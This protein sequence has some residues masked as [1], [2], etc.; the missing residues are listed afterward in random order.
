MLSAFAD[1]APSAIA[2]S[3]NAPMNPGS[4]PVNAPVGLSAEVPPAV[5]DAAPT[6]SSSTQD[7]NRPAAAQP[8][9]A[10]LDESDGR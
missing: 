5:T 9:T 4:W 7:R 1:T 10:R 2:S 3:V 8:P 6:T